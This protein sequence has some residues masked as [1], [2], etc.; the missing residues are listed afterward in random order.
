MKGRSR[1]YAL[2]GGNR[3]GRSAL[4]IGYNDR[5]DAVVAMALVPHERPAEVEPGV[6]AF[7]NGPSVMRWIEVTLGL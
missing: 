5:C 6:I 1:S 7:L 2:A 4:S 3:P